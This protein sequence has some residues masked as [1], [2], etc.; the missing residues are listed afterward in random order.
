[1]PNIKFS[2][3]GLFPTQTNYQIEKFA[4]ATFEHWEVSAVD[5]LFRSEARFM[6][7]S[8]SLCWK[9]WESV[10]LVAHPLKDYAVL[11]KVWSSSGRVFS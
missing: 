8:I 11:V 3:P 4:D 10:I 2:H 1:M 9:F 5:A 7:G 6:P